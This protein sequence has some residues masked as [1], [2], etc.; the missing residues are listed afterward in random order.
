MD[1]VRTYGDR[2][3]VVAVAVRSAQIDALGT[4]TALDVG[5]EIGCRAVVNRAVAGL[6]G[7]VGLVAVSVDGHDWPPG[8]LDALYDLAARHPRAGLLAPSGAAA[9]G[10]PVLLRRAAWDSVDGYDTRI[11]DPDRADADLRARLVRAGW[12]VVTGVGAGRP[13]G[14]EGV[15]GPRCGQGM[16][17]V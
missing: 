4:T 11:A 9:A 16:L 14:T 1:L 6:P 8:T 2:S 5:E 17:S 13:A 3:A 15:D 12:L 10:L 7:Q